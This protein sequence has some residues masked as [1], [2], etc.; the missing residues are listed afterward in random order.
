ML[1]N[2]VK[3]K[4]IFF[5]FLLLLL[6]FIAYA[7]KPAKDDI[8]KT[9]DRLDKQT[10]MSLVYNESVQ[11][12]VDVYTVRRREHL[13]SILAKSDLYFPLFE[14]YLDKYNLPLELK[15]LAVVESALDP[16]ATSTSGAKGLWQF[17]YHASR[18]FDLK[19]DSY[20]DER[21]DPVKSTEAA[22]KYLKYLYDNLHD[23][24]LVLAAYNGGIAQVKMAIEKSN[25]ETDYWKIRE[26]L[27]KETQGYVPAF[28]AVNY[29]MNDY[30][31]YNIQKAKAEIKFDEIGF[32][33][34]DK[35]I[36]FSQLSSLIGVDVEVIEE[37]NPLYTKQFIPVYNEPVQIM[38]PRDK[39][40]LYLKN[41]ELITEENTPPTTKL[42]YGYNRGYIKRV[43]RVKR[44]EFFH[45]IAMEY[46]VRIE[47]V[48][49]WNNLNTREL[50]AGQI[51][52]IWEKPENPVPF[53]IKSVIL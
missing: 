27:S 43:H 22:C 4:Y 17:L 39:V 40:I 2:T 16:R 23:W 10:P 31:F 30:M 47:D 33:F 38:I 52:V 46:K 32:V 3:I 49:K 45:K 35:S 11:A 13:S 5:T 20:V 42:P 6:G 51:L 34:V 28:I 15:Y 21:Y 36:S 41:K 53:N 26:H 8:I 37:L 44:G 9:I 7:H 18:L 19:I 1:K 25:G 14:E 50:N 24:N 29:V 48:Q 12:Y